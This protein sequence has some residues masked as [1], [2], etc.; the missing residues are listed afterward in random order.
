MVDSLL[1]KVACAFRNL[2]TALCLIQRHQFSIMD[3]RRDLSFLIK[4]DELN[5]LST[6]Q[7]LLAYFFQVF[8]ELFQFFFIHVDER[9]AFRFNVFA[10]GLQAFFSF[11]ISLDGLHLIALY[12]YSVKC[13]QKSGKNNQSVANYDNEL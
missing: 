1:I 12:L 3:F 7:G 5:L 9:R 13:R 6:Q 11:N 2:A 10:K 8:N 4:S